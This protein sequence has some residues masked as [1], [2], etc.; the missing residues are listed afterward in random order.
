ME[1]VF[2][3]GPHE[4]EPDAASHEVQG[5]LNSRNLVNYVWMQPKKKA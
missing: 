1:G 2:R 5:F 4:T 3:L